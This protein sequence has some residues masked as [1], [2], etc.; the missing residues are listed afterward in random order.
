MR[1]QIAGIFGSYD[2]FAKAFPGTI[3]L[4]CAISLLP[5]QAFNLELAQSGALIA[6]LTIFVL[7]VGFA[8]GQALHST[9]V[10]VEKAFYWLSRKSFEKSLTIR[11]VFYEEYDGTISVFG[12]EM[13]R[14]KYSLSIARTI[15]TIISLIVIAISFMAINIEQISIPF[16][17]DFL[18]GA[19]IGSVIGVVII[20]NLTVVDFLRNWISQTLIPHRRQFGAELSNTENQ[21]K[22]ERWLPRSF[23]AK[24]DNEY[25]TEDGTKDGSAVDLLYTLVMSHLAHRSI[26]RAR[27]FQAV[28]AFCR[29]MWVTLYLYSILFLFVGLNKT[30]LRI[31]QPLQEQLAELL[32]YSPI[33]LSQA[34]G[35]DSLMVIAVTMFATGL[36]FMEGERQYKSLFVDYVMADFLTID[37]G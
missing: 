32:N 16:S 23:M 12:R 15:D 4:L 8:F 22:E 21:N 19:V 29:S 7:V 6:A 24:V 11:R 31:Y 28:F 9:A 13:E 1:T 36:F 37:N 30:E 35:P 34:G 17:D 10:T 20:Y 2:L 27:Q 33:I 25:Q 26:G 5:Q 18:I 3:F 14:S